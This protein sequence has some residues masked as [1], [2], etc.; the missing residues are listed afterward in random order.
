MYFKQSKFMGSIL[1]FTMILG[2]PGLSFATSIQSISAETEYAGSTV[3]VKPAEEIA[4][5]KAEIER[6]K[7]TLSQ[8]ANDNYHPFC[9]TETA[10][11]NPPCPA[12]K[13]CH[14]IIKLPNKW[15]SWADKLQ[16]KGKSLASSSSGS[17]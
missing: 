15:C 9:P 6:L 3:P 1:A 16:A 17:E 4:H 11:L 10:R 7:G 14:K 8:C 12:G 5:L 13:A 2:V